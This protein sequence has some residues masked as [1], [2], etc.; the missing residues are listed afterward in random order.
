MECPSSH[1]FPE[2][3]LNTPVEISDSTHFQP[4]STQSPLTS[5]STSTTDSQTRSSTR[6]ICP[7][8]EPI[9]ERKTKSFANHSDR[10]QKPKPRPCLKVENTPDALAD[11]EC[12]DEELDTSDDDEEQPVL[13]LDEEFAHASME[14]IAQLEESLRLLGLSLKENL[15]VYETTSR[16]I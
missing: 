8:G 7:I 10:N 6:N 13:C 5:V 3:Q 15:Y 9:S 2:P 12:D 4:L 11:P 1:L 16:S 14:A